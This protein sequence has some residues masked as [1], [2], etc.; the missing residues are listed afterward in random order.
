M[1]EYVTVKNDVTSLKEQ[2]ANLNVQKQSL[3]EQ[4]GEN[5]NTDLDSEGNV[6]L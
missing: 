3:T 1:Q 6:C 4:L 5:V 2:L